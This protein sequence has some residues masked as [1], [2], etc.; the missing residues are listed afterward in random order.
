MLEAVRVTKVFM[1]IFL[2]S[3]ATAIVLLFSIRNLSK[4]QKPIPSTIGLIIGCSG[5]F[6]VFG[7]FQ[8]LKYAI[9]PK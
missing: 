2:M 9:A 3:D 6:L 4:P 7:R 1:Y 5:V 8:K